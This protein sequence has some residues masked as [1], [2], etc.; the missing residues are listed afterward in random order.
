M[1]TLDLHY[2]RPPL[3]PLQSEAFFNSSRYS[4]TEASTKSGKTVGGMVW[5][6]EQALAGKEGHNFWW[7]APIFVK[8]KP[9]TPSGAP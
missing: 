4:I 1:A 3:Y 9:G 2:T 6:V 7:N 8:R 5:L